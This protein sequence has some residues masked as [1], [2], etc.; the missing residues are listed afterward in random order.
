MLTQ[1]IN[2]PLLAQ[3]LIALL[4]AALVMAGGI[5][6][7]VTVG[8][9]FS[10][11]NS[12]LTEQRE[13]AGH[14]KQVLILKN[15]VSTT[16]QP[17]KGNLGQ[18]LFLEAP[19]LTIARADLQSH[20]GALAQSNGVMIDSAGNMPDIL[21]DGL[22][23]IGLRFDMSGRH[24]DVHR[25]IVDIEAGVPPLFVRDWIVRVIGGEAGDQAL[26]I[27]VQFQVFA[28]Y[29]EANANGSSIIDEV[30]VP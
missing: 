12:G 3:R 17:N 9:H 29:R 11:L 16:K 14:L 27:A 8:F 13:R 5:G 15:A 6:V 25:T 20:I 18:R 7:V 10:A 23:M 22:T 26:Q 21:E 2:A 24:D 19:S 4:I 28:A 1:L 30:E